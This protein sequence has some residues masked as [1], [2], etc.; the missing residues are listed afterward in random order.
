MNKLKHSRMHIESFSI[1]LIRSINDNN[2]GREII[3]K[4][5]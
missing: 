2:Q 1:T 5:E 4:F 3:N